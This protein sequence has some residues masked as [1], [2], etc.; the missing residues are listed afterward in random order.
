MKK[1]EEIKK[2]LEE[3]KEKLQ[4]RY[5]MVLILEMSRRQKVT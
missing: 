2:I 5:K 3:H 4:D 1:I